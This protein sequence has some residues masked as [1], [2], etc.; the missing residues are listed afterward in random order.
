MRSGITLLT[1]GT[2]AAVT[3]PLQDEVGTAVVTTQGRHKEI[4]QVGELAVVEA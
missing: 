2:A 4:C 1:A 3:Q